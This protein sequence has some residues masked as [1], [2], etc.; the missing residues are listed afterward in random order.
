MLG[1]NVNSINTALC[2]NTLR[3]KSLIPAND[4]IRGLADCRVGVSHVA[5]LKLRGPSP[6]NDPRLAQDTAR[7]GGHQAADHHQHEAR[8]T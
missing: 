3:F 7:V 6:H 4:P 8:P 2:R 1:P 5:C